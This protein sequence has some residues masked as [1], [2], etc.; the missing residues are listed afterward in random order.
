MQKKV[1]VLAIAAA[2]SAPAMALADSANVTLYGVANVSADYV[3]TGDTD[4]PKVKGV[5]KL[6]VSS[7]VSY[8]GLK[9]SEDL[10]NGMAAVWQIESQ[11]DLDNN[12][13]ALASRNSFVGLK[14]GM[15]TVLMGKHDTP[16]KMATRNLDVFADSIADNRSIMGGVSLNT[17]NLNQFG[18]A[19]ASFDGRQP[20]VLAYV[21]P[22]FANITAVIARVNLSEGR[23]VNGAVDAADTLTNNL[24]LTSANA[25]S[26]AAMY[27]AGPFY[28]SLAYEVH[29]FK[30]SSA[31]GTTADENAIKLG[32]GYT[33]D[34]FSV[35]VAVEQTSD[36][37]GKLSGAA[38]NNMLGHTDI[39]IGGKYN[40][41]SGAVKAAFTSAGKI[42]N[43][44]D[45]EAQ[46]ISIGYDH[47]LSKR[48]TV[49]AIYTMLTNK[50]NAAYG[51]SSA[52]STAG[53]TSVNTGGGANLGGAD[54]SA[55]SL[56]IKHS[57]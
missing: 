57:F 14:S 30:D 55:L 8:V 9:G 15:G 23:T 42:H 40:L 20:N 17:A 41:G 5:S 33:Q 4:T 31:A 46:Q 6:V 12:A 19:G 47:H 1:I 3:T 53:S 27:N 16:Y 43:T 29:N 34:M 54:P 56:G 52:G 37:I 44:T 49:Y 32:F 26:A 51:L 36:T 21:S 13:Q 18:T 11:V 7:N 25:I 45:T 10:G 28:G 22:T 2:L 24:G 35:G 48:T 38:D 39:Y 50:K